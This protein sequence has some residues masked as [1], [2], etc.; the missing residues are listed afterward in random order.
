MHELDEKT[1]IRS[2]DR[3]SFYG[4]KRGAQDFEYYS[5]V[6]ASDLLELGENQGNYREKFISKLMDVYHRQ[7]NCTSA[8]IV[9]PANYNIR[10]HEKAWNSRDKAQENFDHWRTKYFKAVNRVRTPSPEDEIESAVADIDKLL[11][12]QAVAKETNKLIRKYKLDRDYMVGFE[13]TDNEKALSKELLELYSYDESPEARVNSILSADC[14]GNRGYASFELTSI[15]TKVR[16]RKKKIEVMKVR[17]ERKETFEDI[18]FKGGYATIE[19]DRV[20]IYHDEKPERETINQ[21][22]AHGFRYSPKMVC[23]CRKH[24][25]NA[26][27][28]L[29]NLIKLWRD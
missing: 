11:K 3:I 9:G 15:S 26:I 24:T 25:G 29:N 1:M 27:Y 20:V 4:E 12:F 6:L 2:Y 28:D 13:K 10:R 14:F 22:K 7:S 21:I 19:S 5:E 23:W 16:E 8:F 17:I 18:K